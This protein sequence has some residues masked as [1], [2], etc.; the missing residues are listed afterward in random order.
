MNTYSGGPEQGSSDDVQNLSIWEVKANG[1]ST[2]GHNSEAWID[3]DLTT[4][5]GKMWTTNVSGNTATT[6]GSESQIANEATTSNVDITDKNKFSDVSQNKIL[7]K[8]HNRII[9][10]LK[11]DNVTKSFILKT[12]VAKLYK[13]SS[14]D[15]TTKTTQHKQ[16]YFAGIPSWVTPQQPNK[17]MK[18]R[19][20]IK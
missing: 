3:A 2:R 12:D 15:K 6:S 16:V 9:W 5:T 7:Y 17:Y 1:S 11:Y 14:T 18:I 10:E 4:E 19:V 20:V 8:K 13:A